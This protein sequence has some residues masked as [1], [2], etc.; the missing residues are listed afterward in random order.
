MRP[1]LGIHEVVAQERNHDRS[2]KLLD[3]EWY[4]HFVLKTTPTLAFGA[5]SLHIW[6]QDVPCMA[7]TSPYL[8]YG[9]FALAALHKASI[10][11]FAHEKASTQSEEEDRR[12]CLS[13]AEHFHSQA[14]SIYVP[15]LKS[16]TKSSCVPLCCFNMMLSL[17]AYASRSVRTAS[18]ITTE[19]SGHGD[20][21]QSDNPD[22]AEHSS[23][24]SAFAE[25]IKFWNGTQFILDDFRQEI[26][27][28][29]IC[30]LFPT[31]DF[32]RLPPLSEK[33]ESI[34]DSL[35]RSAESE[36]NPEKRQIY[37][38]EIRRLRVAAM[39]TSDPHSHPYV[40]TYPTH[41]PTEV[42]SMLMERDRFLLRALGFWATCFEVL[43]DRWW[44]NGW[45]EELLE[46][47]GPM[48]ARDPKDHMR[49]ADIIENCDKHDTMPT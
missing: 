42:I 10:L 32:E 6:Q 44:C 20:M 1:S 27:Q 9:M 14:L 16:V 45:P 36:N 25:S 26:E 31:P 35:T 39:S 22:A 24:L 47:I 5:E 15:A 13:K 21:A 19:A 43:E 38:H 23:A 2:L 3:L 41:M 18:L 49:H 29:V 30:G 46:E 12:R 48:L 11:T 33:T 28:S 8:L 37:L 40:L 17:Y 34:L 4:H 7:R